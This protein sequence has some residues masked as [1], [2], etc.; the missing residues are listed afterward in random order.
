VNDYVDALGTPKSYVISDINGTPITNISGTY[1]ATITI[2]KATLPGATMWVDPGANASLGSALLI[3]VTVTYGT[4][5][6]SNTII[7]EGYRTQYAPR[8]IP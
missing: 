3:K 2:T 8:V 7:L 5:S 4:N 6:S 1:A